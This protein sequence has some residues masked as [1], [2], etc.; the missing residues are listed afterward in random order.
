MAAILF[1]SISTIAD[2]SEIQRQAFN[3]AFAKHGLDWSWDR[4]EYRGL[5]ASSG[6]RDRVA[7]YAADRGEDVDADAVHATKSELYQQRAA[8]SPLQPRPGVV[9]TIA[10]ARR[11]GDQ[12]ALVTTT[13]GANV[14]AVLEGL[15]RSLDPSSFDVLVDVSQVDRRKP[16]GAAYR[17][18]LERLGVDAGSAVA[19]EDNVGGVGAAR[20]AGVPVV[21]FPNDNTV[22]H[23][24]SAADHTVERVELDDLRRLVSA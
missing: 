7:Q 5:L 15:E 8:A 21:A 19:I 9:E 18:A 22:G 12:V 17:Y 10:R 24:F 6:G 11:E 1:G 14:S 13:A 20:D 23:D 3:D 4:E 16:D 2:T